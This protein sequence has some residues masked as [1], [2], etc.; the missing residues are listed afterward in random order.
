MVV[1][2]SG[3][4]VLSYKIDHAPSSGPLGLH[5]ANALI[6]NH[7]IPGHEDVAFASVDG[8]ERHLV[9]ILEIVGD[10]LGLRGVEEPVYKVEPQLEIGVHGEVGVDG[11]GTGTGAAAIGGAFDSLY[12]EV[13]VIETGLAAS[14]VKFLVFGGT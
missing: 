14:D 9:S 2:D 12:L 11:A 7:C 8:V 1:E 6:C 4:E 13:L 10:L 3:S 5:R